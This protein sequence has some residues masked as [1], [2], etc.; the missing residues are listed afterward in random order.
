MSILKKTR[1]EGNARGIEGDGI[2]RFALAN[3][4]GTA[5]AATCAMIPPKE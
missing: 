5:D 4:C 1:M 3:E 2:R